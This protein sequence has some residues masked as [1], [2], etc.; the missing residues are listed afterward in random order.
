V[1]NSREYYLPITTIS[2]DIFLKDVLNHGV[3]LGSKGKSVLETLKEYKLYIIIFILV[4]VSS[5]YSGLL[6]RAVNRIEYAYLAFFSWHSP[7]HIL[8]IESDDWGR[9][10][11]TRAAA[12][13]LLEN[14]GASNQVRSFLSQR[15]GSEDNDALES[16]DDLEMLFSLLE[17]H[18]D[19]RG[20]HPVV[21]ANVVT[22][23]P[24]IKAI[25]AAKYSKYAFVKPEPALVAKWKEGISRG[26]FFPQYHGL[27]HFNFRSWCRDQ[28]SGD[29]FALDLSAAGLV[30]M[31]GF[32]FRGKEYS[33]QGEYV[34]FTVTPSAPLSY[35]EQKGIVEEGL[36]LFAELFG[37]R[38]TSV[39]APFCIWDETTERCWI[40][41]GIRYIQA[42]QTHFS[43]RTSTGA[44]VL[45]HHYLGERNKH[46]QIYLG[47][48]VDFEP[49][50]DNTDAWKNALKN[51]RNNF[52]YGI[53]SVINT[54]RCNYVSEMSVKLRN[55]NMAQLDSL[56]SAVEQEFPDVVYLTSAQLGEAIEKGYFGNPADGRRVVLAE[57]IGLMK[58]AGHALEV[59]VY[60]GGPYF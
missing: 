23:Y 43:R 21:T 58:R 13:K 53:P 27:V 17:K 33:Y 51:I 40:E 15:S 34:D 35:G 31:P 1:D 9:S 39:I 36:R 52:R 48:N 5:I 42:G 57:K 59:L 25:R 3:A 12:N 37:Y 56:L 6:K 26:V 46:G 30:S 60:G 28:S 22:S 32:R 44:K 10:G 54:H 47:R 2:Q 24:D 41:S 7:L 16:V 11:R 29:R 19:S 50:G 55:G 18:K 38:S 49:N 20:V 14:S 45:G 8:V 4:I